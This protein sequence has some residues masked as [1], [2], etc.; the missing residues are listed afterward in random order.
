MSHSQPAGQLLTIDDLCV[1]M[2]ELN[3]VHAKWYIIGVHLRVSVGTL[4][5]IN[6]QYSNPSDCLRETLTTWLKSSTPTWSNIVDALNVV[7][8]VRLAAD[9][10][11]K[12]CSTQDIATTH[13]HI[14][15]VPVIPPA[16]TH[17]WMTPA[18]QS[19]VPPSISIPEYNSMNLVTKA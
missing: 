3:N 17:I 9:L 13:Q 11:H 7:D 2:K 10:E 4:D 6:N 12:Y 18:P 1:V 8:E 16:Q 15:P 14:P 19:T 5:A